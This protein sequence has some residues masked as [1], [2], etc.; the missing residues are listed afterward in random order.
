MKKKAIEKIPYIGI[1]RTS[2]KR[3][4]KYIAATMVKIVDHEKHLITEVYRN[5]K[6]NLTV[7]LVRIV[8]TK[9]D[10]GTFFTESGEWSRCLISGTFYVSKY[11]VWDKNGMKWDAE[12]ENVIRSD[13]DLQRIKRFPG[14]TER[15]WRSQTWY[16]LINDR[17]EDISAKERRERDKR[18]C[19]RRQQGL[20]E[21]EENT[22]EIDERKILDYAD[23][24]I[25]HEKH[26]LYYKKDGSWVRVAC[27]KCGGV[28]D[29]RW[30]PGIS[31]ESQFMPMISE[32]RKGGLGTCP[33]CGAQGEWEP[34]GK[35][36]SYNR[37]RGHI[38][39]GQK[40]RETGMVFRYFEVEK[41]YQL[42]LICEER[43]QVMENAR[44]KL[45][46][47]EIARVYFEEGKM[48]QKDYHKYNQYSGRD[49]WDDCNLYGTQ[50][51]SIDK[52]PILKETYEEMRGTFLQYSAMQEYAEAES[53]CIN[54]V[55]YAE[56]YMEYPQIEMLT[57][58]G[59]I[60][61]VESM[62]GYRLEIVEDICANRVDTFLG[63]RKEH[64]RQLIRS[65]G[66][67]DIL[68]VMQMERRLGQR[69]TDEQIEKIAE[70]KLDTMQGWTDVL[71][72]IGIQKMLNLIGKYA[73]VGVEYKIGCSFALS[74][75]R[76]VAQ[77]YIDYIRMRILLGYDMSNTV[78][79]APRDLNK[80]HQRMVMEFNKKEADKR[81]KEVN[82]KYPLIK[83][84]YRRL[85]KQFCYEDEVL[86]IRPAR[87]AGEIVMEGRILHHC[88]GLDTYLKKH[89]DGITTILF[90]RKKKE[91]DVPYIT[92]EIRPDDFLIFQ[93]YGAHDK[94]PDKED[95]EMWLNKYVT[96]LKCGKIG[97]LEAG[98]Q[99]LAM[100]A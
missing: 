27:S 71:K 65:Q 79:L 53:G 14:I 89:N 56:L 44:E 84:H 35:M 51:I 17:I 45:S 11:P 68:K 19:Q 8:L 96:K 70:L 3:G 60:K 43:G 76:E 26:Y 49:F 10:F 69:W 58:L 13:E 23:S 61:V 21:R 73:G 82:I 74:R 20:K 90:L 55:R 1:E 66:D 7:P 94:K 37:N 33:L 29:R 67:R 2:R 5:K 41:E 50:S 85:R 15:R 59:L 63:I 54:P 32:P 88:V 6:E 93:W 4:A 34:Q 99:A 86:C 36:K 22:P 42:G 38:F 64:I 57:K 9:K 95:I 31:Y 77:T 12:K 72:Y 25:F 81:I 52:A 92:V 100:L 62:M 48:P 97:T 47:I 18:R 98:Q 30:K 46:G 39:I 83:K 91:P 87:D 24:V 28:T 78:Y 16:E 75:L 80:N 40:Y